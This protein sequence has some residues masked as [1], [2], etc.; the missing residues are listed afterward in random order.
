VFGLDW[1]ALGGVVCAMEDEGRIGHNDELQV[2]RSE[3]GEHTVPLPFMYG[4]DETQRQGKAT[5]ARE[6]IMPRSIA[7]VLNRWREESV[8][9]I[10]YTR[11]YK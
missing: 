2:R 10:I 9:E 4:G 7:L 8:E 11:L 3:M 5:D 6:W 1:L